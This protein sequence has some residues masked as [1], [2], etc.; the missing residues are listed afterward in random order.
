MVAC[1]GQSWNLQWDVALSR[2]RACARRERLKR[3]AIP[4]HGPRWHVLNA[5]GHTPP[6]RLA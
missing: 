5:A 1:I 3:I 6:R 4:I 2:R